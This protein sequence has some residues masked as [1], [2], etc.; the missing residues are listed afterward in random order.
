VS[1]PAGRAPQRPRPTPSRAERLLL[2]AIVAIAVVVRF[3]R[4]DL[5]WYFL[6]QVR[7]VTAAVD[8]A[9]G[10]D[11]PLLGPRI[12]STA[13]YLGPLY[14]YLLAIPFTV[15]RDPIAAPVFVA[16]TQLAALLALY[17]FASEYFGRRVGAAAAALFAVFPLTVFSSR[18]VWHVG[19]LPLFIVLY[20]H[21]L[22]RLVID[23]RPAAIVALCA[24]LAVLTQL[25]LTA[26]ALGIVALV[27]VTAFRPKLP[28]HYVSA[29]AA[30]F[31]LLYLPYL[32]H[33]LAHGFANLGA[34]VTASAPG[35]TW[36]ADLPGVSA[37]I[38]RLFAPA[39]GGF[40][41]EA[42]WPPL[43]L[44]GFWVMYGA[45]ALLFAI[46]IA[47]SAFHLLPRASAGP[48]Q[49][50]DRRRSAL[51]LMWI[52]LPVL[53]V[54][55][56]S[57]PVWWYY[58]DVIYPCPFILAGIGLTSLPSLL[59]RTAAQNA[60][61]AKTLAGVV[62]A[63]VVTQ[64]GFL[65]IFQRSVAAH[66]EL[67]IH[68]P[69]VTITR[70]PSP[71]DLLVTLPLGYR[72]EIVR[73]LVD[74]FGIDQASFRTNVH[75]AILGVAEE[76][77]SLVSAFSSG[78]QRVGA[79]EVAAARHPLVTRATHATAV[80]ALGQSRTIGPYAVVEQRPIVD[81][82]SVR[83]AT[84]ARGVAPA[85]EWQPFEPGA[86]E[87][88]IT[89]QDA[90]HLG[91]RGTLRLPADVTLPPVGVSVV[92]WAPFAVDSLKVADQRLAPIARRQRQ[93]PLML[94]TAA[95]QWSM[96]VGWASETVFD[97]AG[98]LPPGEHQF[99]VQVAGTGA[100][101]EFDMYAG[102]SWPDKEATDEH[103]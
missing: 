20:M 10:I 96:G 28:I 100:L 21:A 5:T 32:T 60:W 94:R 102:R 15:A 4:I 88:A 24:L 82:A 54:S 62:V 40:I 66:G 68:V 13:A 89:L 81:Y 3:Y 7:D 22:F 49:V 17:R 38:A 64:A 63:T 76:S 72:R 14:F 6:D 31:P 70:T 48:A 8:I 1:G 36:F 47:V 61:M 98:V 90:E 80:A 99:V 25:H 41:V 43:F 2:A 30:L 71:F 55:G 78:R 103:R 37:H 79:G 67:R 12:G 57:T 59:A 95:G 44:A 65:L 33:E 18:L 23:G 46:G 69:S 85:P 75:G 11:L 42:A 35:T 51:L 83:C 101:I 27:A 19:L 50:M 52:G 73:T 74:D 16:L 77:R 87:T 34:L 53:I 56:R 26:A 97:L 86:A 58:L 91:C 45:E 93:T 84:S 92:G 39:L 9:T 29:G